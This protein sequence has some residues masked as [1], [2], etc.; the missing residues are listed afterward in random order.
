MM[1][2]KAPMI[3][4]LWLLLTIAE[5]GAAEIVGRVVDAETGQGI[6]RAIVRAIPLSRNQREIQ[7]KS[8]SAGKYHLELVQGKYRLF[9]SLPDSNYLSKFYSSSNQSLGDIIDV[10]TFESFRIIDL[11]LSSGGS[12]EG[13]VHRWADN[14]PVANIR[15]YAISQDFRISETTKTNGSYR[16]R[17]LPLGEYRLQV[18]PLDENFVSVYFDGTRD[19]SQATKVLLHHRQAVDGIDFRLRY[20]G[21]ISGRAFANKS[22]EPIPGLK[23]IAENHNSKE[24]PYFAVS[25]SQGFYPIRG[26][27]EG[28]YTLET[29]SSREGTQQSKSR[30]S[31]LVQYHDGRF[32]R[33]LADKLEIESGSVMNGINFAMVEEAMVS[34]TVRSRYQNSVLPDVFI[35]SQRANQELL[36]TPKARTNDEGEYLVSGLA[37]GEYVFE[38]ALPSKLS[39]LV[40]FFYRE[41][42]S[43]EKADKIAIEEGARVR[44]ID[45]N[46]PLGATLKGRLRVTDPDYALNPQVNAVSLSREG[47]DLEGYGK[48]NFK[49]NRDG[50]FTIEGAP[51]GRYALGPVLEDPNL[52]PQSNSEEKILDVSGGDYIDGIELPMRVVGSIS[53]KVSSESPLFSLDKITLLLVNLKDNSRKYLDFVSERYVIAGL[54]PGQYLLLLLT[55]PKSYQPSEMRTALIFD[56]RVVEVHKGKTTT[57]VNFQISKN[58]DRN[59][60]LLP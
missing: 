37:P 42:F 22:R 17:A 30:T 56:T 35:L 14:S 2:P 33:E 49:L 51:P 10:P 32:D 5:L 25:D 31:Y 20:G 16:F 57:D 1:T 52:T 6:D 58:V 39:R 24:Q 60:G 9:V 13:T 15:V 41:K 48:R 34:G 43:V 28:V 38:T 59:S 8:S 40:S 26:L 27:T 36:N 18:V 55:N 44:H 29:S 54:E 3:G 11:S 45:F 50:M 7:T 46:L 19:P 53:G 47:T 12:I 4:F 21:T 23:I